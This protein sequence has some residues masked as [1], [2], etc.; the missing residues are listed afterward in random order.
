[1]EVSSH[2]GG[3]FWNERNQRERVFAPHA[4]QFEHAVCFI[5]AYLKIGSLRT[6]FTV[7]CSVISSDLT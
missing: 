3:V 4:S 7:S 6:L 5:I 2:V 1:M